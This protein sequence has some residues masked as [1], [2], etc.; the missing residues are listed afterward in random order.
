MWL[1]LTHPLLRTW[2][3]TQACALTGNR[4]GDSSLCR[5]ALNPLSH[6][7]QGKSQR[8]ELCTLTQSCQSLPK[9]VSLSEHPHQRSAHKKEPSFS[10]CA[11]SSLQLPS[12]KA[13]AIDVSVAPVA[14]ANSAA[15]SAPGHR[16]P[17]VVALSP[18]L[19]V[20]PCRSPGLP[21]RPGLT[22]S[23]SLRLE[24]LQ[25][26]PHPGRCAF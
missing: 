4:T 11:S 2:P 5:V 1:P 14:T 23:L 25:E 24:G 20:F 6:T 9:S 13:H 22:L 26:S 8:S 7:S 3:A 10:K 12:F 16:G 15:V 17:V 21:A 19:G 18:S